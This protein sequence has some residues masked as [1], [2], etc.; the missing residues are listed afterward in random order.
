MH[1]II[2]AARGNR[3]IRGSCTFMYSWFNSQ[4]NYINYI[5][6]EALRQI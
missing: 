1:I 3:Q 5:T 2:I 6:L 4:P